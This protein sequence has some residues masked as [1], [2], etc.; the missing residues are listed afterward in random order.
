M[1]EKPVK[2]IFFYLITPFLLQWCVSFGVQFL[3]LQLLG[4]ASL[5]T[6]EISVV[7]AIL[8]IPI[9]G[10]L[11]RK[12]TESLDKKEI[13]K[14]SKKDI[15]IVWIIGICSCILWNSCIMFTS[16]QDMSGAYQNVASK[17]YESSVWVQVKGMGIIVPAMEELLYRGLLY[18]RIRRFVSVKGAVLIT[19]IVFGVLHGNLVQ[20]VFATGLGILL[21]IAFE[22]YGRVEMAIQM[23]VA[24]NL[25]SVFLT[26]IGGFDK[27]LSGEWWIILLFATVIDGL[28]IWKMLQNCYKRLS[29]IWG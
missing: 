9:A 22:R 8:V 21:A 20:F 23:H 18:R 17:I 14:I 29:K 24:I 28:C 26:G 19:A 3:A 11:Y 12:D 6:A 25:T 15:L 5:Y 1:K 2:S 27:I 4:N 13:C 7:I 16:I 10:Y